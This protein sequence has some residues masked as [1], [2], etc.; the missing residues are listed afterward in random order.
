MI[1]YMYSLVIFF[2][3]F[4]VAVSDDSTEKKL[5]VSDDSTEKKL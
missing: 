2:N 1:N 3:L 4:Y 5:D